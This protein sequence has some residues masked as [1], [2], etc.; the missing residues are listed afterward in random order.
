M[1]KN[2]VLMLATAKV[3][4]ENF[5]IEK[6]L[7]PDNFLMLVE[8][9]SFSFESESGRYIVSAGECAH[10]KQNTFY[11][12]KIIQ[13][14]KIHVFR[15]QAPETL[16]DDEY[17][18]FRDT[19]RIKSTIN[20]LNHIDN[21]LSLDDFERKTH[22]FF[23]IINQYILENEYS[24]ESKDEDLLIKSA[25]LKIQSRL[26]D[27]LPFTEFSKEAGLSYVQFLRRFK[28]YTGLTPAKYIN[29][30]KMKKARELLTDGRLQIKEISEKLGFEN[31]YY[32]SNFFKKN[33]NV[34]PS[35]YRKT[36][37]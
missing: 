10:L 29:A 4:R 37:Q 5:T 8:D 30:L 21:L 27:N 9:G 17:L 19:K 20:F 16:V 7:S 28:A 15:Y 2:R 35:A 24:T 22:L 13:P 12:R 25:V 11:V 3:Y 23:D 34:S 18:T 1:D 6:F 26:F 32:F 36:I 14:A 31:E 33:M